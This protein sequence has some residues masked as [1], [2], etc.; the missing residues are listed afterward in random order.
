MLA[1]WFLAPAASFL[2]DLL[3]AAPLRRDS[4]VRC[5]G[6]GY[7]AST[8]IVGHA[9]TVMFLMSDGMREKIAGTSGTKKGGKRLM[10]CVR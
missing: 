6:D 1:Q 10:F 4:Q 3:P 8:G 5:C 9:C 7:Y 2:L